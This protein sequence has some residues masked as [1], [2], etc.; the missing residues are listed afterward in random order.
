[1]TPVTTAELVV[2]SACLL[3]E[4]PTWD[5]AGERLLWLDIDART[6]HRLGADGRHTRVELGARVTAVVPAAGGGLRRGRRLRS[7]PSRRGRRAGRGDRCAAAGR[8]RGHQRRPLRSGRPPVGR[9]R[10]PLGRRRGGAVPRVPR[11]RGRDR[12][13]AGS[14]CRTAS[15]GAPTGAPATTSTRSPAA[16]RTSTSTSRAISSA[17]ASSPRSTR[18]RTGS[19]STPRAASGSRSGTAAR[20]T[21]T[22]PDGRLDRVVAVPGGFVTSCAFGGD[23][24]DA[25]HH[26][27]TRRPAR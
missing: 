9:H 2:D 20:C 21:A 27:G 13:G 22:V 5:A 15:T 8:R 26:D 12:S 1:M 10:R 17:P 7:G 25:L 18:S 24:H 19:P 14:G 6:L 11:R 3:G 4:G 23:E 16:S